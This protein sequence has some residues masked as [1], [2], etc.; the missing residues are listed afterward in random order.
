MKKF[1]SRSDEWPE[2]R[3][4]IKQTVLSDESKDDEEI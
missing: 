3:Y 4:T 2:M 1:E